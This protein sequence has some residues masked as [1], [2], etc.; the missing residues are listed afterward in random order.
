MKILVIA[1]T[2]FFVSKGTSIRILE[3]SLALERRGH[4]LTIATYHIGENINVKIKTKIEIY[5]IPKI[6]FWY[7][8]IEAGP[9]WQKIILDF[10]LIF[11]VLYLII[12]KK[13]QLIHSH[14]HEGALIGWVAKKIFFWKKIKL[15]TDLH[16]SLTKEMVS[17]KYLNNKILYK[18]FIKL[19]NFI[20]TLGDYVITSSNELTEIIKK[21]SSKKIKTILDGVNLENYKLN[22]TKKELK[23]ELNI[24][25]EKYVIIYTGSLIMNKGIK[26]LLKAIPIVTSNNK[27]A[28]FIIAGY[29][30]EKV[31]NYI[32]EKKL[33]QCVKIINPLNYFDLPQINKAGDIGI[34]PKDSSVGQ[35]SGKILQY[36]GA[37]IPVVCFDRPNNRSYLGKAAYYSKE[38]SPQGIADGILYFLNNPKQIKIKGELAGE[39]AKNFSWEAPALEIEK[40]YKSL[41]TN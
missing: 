6:L 26:N 15:V 34:D 21:N 13:P 17:H 8:K 24:P 5:R 18:I 22:K 23:E 20:N 30:I 11:K 37:K 10:F 27:N 28:Y 1:P 31:K 41:I 2:P 14:L 19:E 33:D 4:T 25:N 7:K 38:K 3:E 32:K 9:D 29:P 40:T 36:M 12:K 16:G 39:R 35:A